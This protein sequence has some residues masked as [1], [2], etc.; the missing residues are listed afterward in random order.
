MTNIIMVDIDNVV[1]DFVG[2]FLKHVN[3]KLDIDLEGED[4]TS[5][6]VFNILGFYDYELIDEVLMKDLEIIEGI[7]YALEILIDRG[8]QIH[9]VTSRKQSFLD[10]TIE[11][12]D[13]VGINEDM[14]DLILV[15]QGDK[16]DYVRHY[17]PDI[18]V[19][20]RLKNALKAKWVKPDLELLL[21]KYP[22]NSKT[23][24]LR[25]DI[26]FFNTSGEMLIKCLKLLK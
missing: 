25:G 3:E 20:D 5:F 2:A 16:S 10:R 26:D 1:L 24:N 18:M 15:N 23:L 12:L 11:N 8:A 22:Y 7:D 13:R 9:L 14:Y 19:E 6:D 21:K 17:Q 4:L